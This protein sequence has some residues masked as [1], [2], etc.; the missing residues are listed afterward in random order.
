MNRA[1]VSCQCGSEFM[2]CRMREHANNKLYI[3]HETAN[4]VNLYAAIETTGLCGPHTCRHTYFHIG[5]PCDVIWTDPRA[6]IRRLY[7][8][9]SIGA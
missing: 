4:A 2:L 3:L 8:Q 6:Q 1:K 7:I 5:C 9:T